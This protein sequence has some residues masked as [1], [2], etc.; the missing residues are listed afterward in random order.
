[1]ESRAGRARS[2]RADKG[3]VD[4]WGPWLEWTLIPHAGPVDRARRR[5]T[6]R[7]L[8]CSRAHHDANGCRTARWHTANMR[9]LRNLCYVVPAARSHATL[10]TWLPLLETRSSK[11][12]QS[13]SELV[14]AFAPKPEVNGGAVAA[15][16]TSPR[17]APGAAHSRKFWAQVATL[18]PPFTAKRTHAYSTGRRQ[19][20][21]GRAC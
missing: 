18:A 15:S 3:R 11:R 5:H 20:G 12:R 9:R 13:A 14:A 10:A 6:Q 4:P 19:S 7:C 1:M 21:A 16:S 8:A 2:F 17:R